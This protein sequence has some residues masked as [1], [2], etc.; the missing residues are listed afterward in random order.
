MRRPAGWAGWLRGAD[1]VKHEGISRTRG[2]AFFPAP[3]HGE[4]KSLYKGVRNHWP[5][6][7]QA[8]RPARSRLETVLTGINRMT[9][10]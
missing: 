2:M 3:S 4:H 7:R 8:R 5:A 9:A 6:S 1:I 10:R